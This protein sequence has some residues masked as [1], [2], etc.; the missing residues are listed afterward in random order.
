MTLANECYDLVDS[1]IRRLDKDL[2]FLDQEA[3]KLTG[4]G[5]AAAPATAPL[6][7]LGAACYAPLLTGTRRSDARAGSRAKRAGGGCVRGLGS[8]PAHG[9]PASAAGA[10]EVVDPNEPKYCSCQRV[11]FGDMIACENDACPIEWFHY[12]CVGLL[13]EPTGKWYC[14]MCAMFKSASASGAKRARPGGEG[15]PG[16]A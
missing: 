8:E 10:A 13:E 12:D 6:P 4:D 16:T 2:A 14:P 5:V 1:H 15:G 9:Q 7:V 3:A 11:S